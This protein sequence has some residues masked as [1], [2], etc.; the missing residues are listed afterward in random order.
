MASKTYSMNNISF[1]YYYR[2]NYFT[3][4]D[5]NGFTQYVKGE[6]TQSMFDKEGTGLFINGNAYISTVFSKSSYP[7]SSNISVG[8]Y[9][10]GYMDEY[11]KSRFFNKYG[12]LN[13]IY[14][15]S[16]RGNENQCAGYK[17]YFIKMG[18]TFKFIGFEGEE[19]GD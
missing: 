14:F 11:L 8:K 6:I 4:I 17:A 13:E 15:V 1:P 9:N 19:Q 2:C 5:E 12:S 7:T 10:G 3:F 16:E 18:N